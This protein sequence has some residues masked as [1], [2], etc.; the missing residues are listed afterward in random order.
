MLTFPTGVTHEFI[1][2]SQLIY[3][4]IM[5]RDATSQ[6]VH[7]TGVEVIDKVH[8]RLCPRLDIVRGLTSPLAARGSV[9]CCAD[10]GDCRHDQRHREAAFSRSFH[11]VT[12]L[13]TLCIFSQID[14]EESA[15]QNGKVCVRPGVDATLDELRRKYNGLGSLLVR[16]LFPTSPANELTNTP[17]DSRKS[18]SRSR[19]KCRPVL[20]ASSRS[21]TSLSSAT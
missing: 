13:L 10:Q 20:P 6:L 1:S 12:R 21:S 15:R 19:R 18:R 16:V 4:A 17:C 7:K 3:A 2:T 11:A 9:R 8:S 14:W 5:I